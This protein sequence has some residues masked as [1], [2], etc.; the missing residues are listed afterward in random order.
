MRRSRTAGDCERLRRTL[1]AKLDGRIRLEVE[2]TDSLPVT[3]LGKA[4]YV[5]QRIPGLHA[6]DEMSHSKTAARS[7]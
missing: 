2:L 7:D 5:D 3:G 1:D 6:A 4:I